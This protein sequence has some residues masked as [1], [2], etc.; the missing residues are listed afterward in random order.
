MDARHQTERV[1][2]AIQITA[3]KAGNSRHPDLRGWLQQLA[4]TNRL[5]VAREGISLTDELAAVAKK[6]ELESA[7]MFPSPDRHAIRW[8]QTSL[9][10]VAGLRIRSAFWSTNCCRAFKKRFATRCPGWR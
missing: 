4:A 5:A 9:P 7:V 6:L 2:E 1:M 3:T 8:S 10:T